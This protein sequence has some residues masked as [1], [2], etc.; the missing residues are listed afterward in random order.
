LGNLKLRTGRL[1]PKVKENIRNRPW[2]E[3]HT[4]TAP[5][6]SSIFGLIGLTLCRKG[7]PSTLWALLLWGLERSHC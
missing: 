5:G 4:S 6:P 2:V 3:G 7:S 1:L